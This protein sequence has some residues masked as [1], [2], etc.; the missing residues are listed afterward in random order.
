MLGSDAPL[1]LF[2]NI[3]LLGGLAVH[4]FIVLPRLTFGDV[5]LERGEPHM[6]FAQRDLWL[7]V[8][9][10]FVSV[11]TVAFLWISATL[12]PG[13]LPSVPTPAKPP[14]PADNI[15]LGGPLGYRYCSTCNIFRPPRSKHCN[16]CNVC[17][18]KFD[19]HCP[20][21]GN[22]IG[23]RNHAHF[24]WFLVFVSALTMTVAACCVRLLILGYMDVAAEYASSTHH[25]S[26]SVTASPLYHN[27]TEPLP[28]FAEEASH[29]EHTLGRNLGHTILAMPV[30]V[31]MGLFCAMCSWSLVSLAVFHA[32]IISVAQTTN[33]RVRGVYRYRRHVNAADHGCCVNWKNALCRK[34][35]LSLLPDFHET[36]EVQD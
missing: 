4:F 28:T 29:L 17:V 14:L 20:W 30:I 24:F 5:I 34:A 26:H 35:P 1:F 16:S 36:I 25:S 19:H 33:E 12:D 31:L 21:V 18:S 32:M 13:I 3:L 7:W 6:V 22:C 8:W 2:T 23:E 11:G 15:P 27:S 10:V 9:S